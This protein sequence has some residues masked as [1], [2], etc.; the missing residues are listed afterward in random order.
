MS[1]SLKPICLTFAALVLSAPAWA[2]DLVGV[3]DLAVENDPRLQAAASR[4]EAT[5]ENKAIARANLLPQI[6]VGANLNYGN[7]DTTYPN[8]F[9]PPD[10][11]LVKTD[12][13]TD[14]YG[15][16]LRQSLYRQANYESLDVARGQVSQAEA[17]YE[18]AYQDFL[19]RVAESYFLV[20]TLTDGV[21]FAEAEEKAFQRQYEQAEQRFEVGLTAVTD[22]HEARASYDN[23][24]A[25]AIVA[26]ND[27]EDAKE[28]LREL[29]GQYFEQYD[30]LQE[31]LPLVEPDPSGADQWVDIS[32]R[33]NPSV[34]SSRAGL[35]V[36]EANVRLARSGHFPTLDLVGSYNKFNNNKYLYTDPVTGQQLTG[37][38][39]NEESRLLLQLQFPLYQGGRVN[40]QTRQARYL[41]DASGQDL[42]DVQRGVVRQT[43]TAY[44]AVIAGIQEVEAFEQARISAES[45]LEAT[46]AGFEVGTRT[47]VDVLIAE[48]RKYQ[49]QR[50]NSLARHAYIIRHLRLKSVAGLLNAEDLRVVN[51][52]LQ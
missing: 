23:A 33:S 6:G 48:Q 3:H 10:R 13:D 24:R 45:A 11:R 40:A 34:L 31:V 43:Q 32:L 18:I 5:R 28:A 16:E 26:R 17:I 19:L 37:E 52:L 41:M 50:D 2:V 8:P 20:L 27:L 12:I 15:A 44:R 51:Q 14:S 9:P 47:I 39:E 49:A 42:D 36:A 46:Q 29:T 1:I 30:A 4:L 25:R 22:V 38:L 35:E 7:S 21:T